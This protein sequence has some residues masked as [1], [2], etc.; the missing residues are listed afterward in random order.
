VRIPGL[1]N[2]WALTHLLINAE[3]LVKEIKEINKKIF[4]SLL[5]SVHIV[6]NKFTLILKLRNPT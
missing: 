4:K 3:S 2:M 5:Y 1:A 6:P